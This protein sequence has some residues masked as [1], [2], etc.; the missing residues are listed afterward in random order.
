[1]GSNYTLTLLAFLGCS[2]R[3]IHTIMEQLVTQLHTKV[4]KD[5]V[6]KDNTCSIITTNKNEFQIY[7]TF[8]MYVYDFR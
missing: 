4:D 6:Q 5:I 3:E 2:T 1:M 7:L 8:Y